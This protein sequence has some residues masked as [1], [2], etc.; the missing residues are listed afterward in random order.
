M[1]RLILP[2]VTLSLLFVQCT[3]EQTPKPPLAEI[4]P[5]TDT[6]FGMELT[7]DYRYLENLDDTLV[8]T[9]FKQQSDYARAIID[10]IPGRQKLID[11]MMEFDKRQSDVVYNLNITEGDRYFYLKQTPE[12]ET[13][14]LFYRDGFSGDEKLL[15]DPEIYGDTTK[16]YVIS[17]V[18]PSHD[19]KI[20]AFAVA[21][22]G[23]ESETLMLMDVEKVE[24]LSESIE[25]FGGAVSWLKDD[26]AFTYFKVNSDDVHDPNRMIDTKVYLHYLGQKQEEDKAVFSRAM[27][28][29][30]DIYPEEIPYVIY[31]KDN[32]LIFAFLATVDNRLKVFYTKLDLFLSGNV[33]WKIL[34]KPED[35]VHNFATTDK[36]I[37]IYSAKGAPNF[38][39]LKASLDN[40]DI[41]KAKVFIT[42]DPKAKLS[43]FSLTKHGLYYSKSYN[44][45]EEKLFYTSYDKGTQKEIQMPEVAGTLGINSKGFKFD[46][47]WVN[48]SGWTS[49]N[50]RFRYMAETGEFNR[51][52]MSTIVDYPEYKNLV[53]EEIMVP[54]YDGTEVPLSIIRDKDTPVDGSAPLVMVGYGAYGISYSP[55]FSPNRYLTCL[56]GGVYAVAHIRGGGE[57]GEAWHMGGFKATKPNTW[58]DFIACAEY[59]VDNKY[60]SPQKIAIM[61]GSAGGILIGRSMTERPDLFRVAVPVVGE[62]NTVR[63]EQAPS[64]PIN[65][66]EF[67]TVQDSAE[68]M[69]LLA[70]DAYHALKDSTNYPSTL[71]T[72]G[73]NDPRVIAW[74]PGKF[75]AKLQAVNTSDNPILFLVDYAAGHGIGDSKTKSFEQW[76]DILSF[77]MWQTGQPGFQP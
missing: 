26:N 40:F 36:D 41:Q 6:Y 30:L 2:L 69:G 56:N 28:P 73:M 47:V 24:M 72:A 33:K 18:S 74:Q 54:S 61:G 71:I 43:G 17:T 46:D 3:Q 34:F 8:Q 22:D 25:N 29:N 21:A 32:D 75:A 42:E 63:S 64:G 37:Y 13:G 55:Y 5:V 62:M 23:S 1:K 31:N 27:Y 77:I 67:G 15:F 9:W 35:N 49:N 65:V 60:T 12:D 44:G 76:A 66:P 45:V 58:K 52:Q 19:G 68:F 51:E 11:K 10:G 59:L 7:D 53:V 39:L 14:K 4:R 38:Q 70:M 48:I 57:L 50:K 20:L 16:S